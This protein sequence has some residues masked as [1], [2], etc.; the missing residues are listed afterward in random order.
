[1]FSWNKTDYINCTNPHG[2]TE[3]LTQRRQMQAVRDKMAG[4]QP[5][6]KFEQLRAPFDYLFEVVETAEHYPFEALAQVKAEHSDLVG[7]VNDILDLT[8]GQRP[9]YRSLAAIGPEL[10]E[11]EWLWPGWIPKGFLTLLAAAPGVGKSYLT[12]DIAQRLIGG[13]AAPDGGEFAPDALGRPIIY[14]DAEDFLP[15]L[16]QR[17]LAW[18]MDVGRFY[19]FQ[20]PARSIIDLANPEYQD[21][22]IDM[23]WDLRPSLIIVDSLSRV[24]R[25]GENSVEEVREVLD[26]MV[27]IPQE[28]NCGM[29]L[30]HHL[31]K[32]S[33][34]SQAGAPVTVHDIRGSGDLIA[35]GRSVLGMD[36]L[37][38]DA[39]GD[40]NGPRRLKVL[41]TNLCQYPEPLAVNFRSL[42]GNEDYVEIDYNRAALFEAPPAKS[43]AE[44]CADWLLEVLEEGP[45]SYSDLKDYLLDELGH[46]ESTLQRARKIL[47]DRVV[48]TE[49]KQSPTNQWVL[50][51][52][53]EDN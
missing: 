37:Q 39:N 17:V 4:L 19:P 45:K 31:R 49:A 40:A 36:A 5:A 3:L 26:I 9:E 41:K 32:K 51:E 47:A 38:T 7:I 16:Y 35:A 20:R 46:S 14:V 53:H 43:K 11:I 13:Q 50:A 24:N 21:H 28:F 1:M 22:L 23:T 42:P 27:S 12:L 52:Q 48:D 6:L 10:P 8:P 25:R 33:S 15:V 30:V 2:E 29:V 34:N 44:E 18:G